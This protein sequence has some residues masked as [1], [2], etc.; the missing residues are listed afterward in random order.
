MKKTALYVSLSLLALILLVYGQVR[1]FEFVNFDDRDALLGNNHI[2]DGLSLTGIGWAFTSSYAANWF[3]VTWLSHM[4]D[5]QLFG[6]D[7]G[8]HHVANLMI[9]AVSALLLFALLRRMTGRLWES[10]FVSFVFALHP[11]H[12]ESVA[13]VS[14]RKDVLGAFFWFLTT[15]LYL[16]YVDK[17]DKRRYLLAFAAYCLGLMSKQM[18]VT[19]PFTLLLLDYWP[20]VRPKTTRVLLEKIPYFAASVAASTIAYQVQHQAGAV[21]ASDTLP[22]ATRAA[23]A[24]VSY[25]SYLGQ[26]FWPV[27]LAV[28]YP[29]PPSIPAW[30]V[31]GCATG[32]LAITG[33]ALLRPYL[34]VGWFWYLG[35]L[36]PVI[37]IVQ[38]GMQAKADRYTYIP[39]VG[40]SMMLAWGV[41]EIMARWPKTKSPLQVASAAVCLVWL[42]ITWTQVPYWRN[43]VPLFEHAI[44]T[45][46]NNFI[47]HLNLGVVLAEQGRANDALRHLYTAVEEKPGHADAHDT[48]GA[49]LGQMGRTAD[50]AEQFQQ[51]IRLQPNDSEA[52]CNLGN[53][54]L[55]QGKVSEAANEFQAALRIVPD[56]ATARFG[57]G[58]ALLNLGRTADSIPQ[59]QEALRLDPNL[60]PARDALN[61]ALSLQKQ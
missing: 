15:W 26:F 16:D 33:L 31:I 4:L 40:V 52:H 10:A 12:V 47:A 1:H 60:T 45:T 50:A 23:N 54:L 34:T 22:I 53:A 51:A 24:V 55:A 18:L 25:I 48:L 37:G 21:L 61:K 39:M 43:S 29:Y 8:W 46:E 56:F 9:H 35:T 3:P 49:L 42:A 14:E 28:F 19:L 20:L 30:Q 6:A 32:L 38:I 41:A 2:R 7:S 44:A 57:L 36:V 11:L 5:F 13:W 27:G 17:P 58:V 59:L